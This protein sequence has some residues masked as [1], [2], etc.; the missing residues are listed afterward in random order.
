MENLSKKSVQGQHQ[1]KLT[2]LMLKWENASWTLVK[3]I[4][5]FK[6]RT[7]YRNLNENQL[8][9]QRVVK[10]TCNITGSQQKQLCL[11]GYLLRGQAYKTDFLHPLID[12]SGNVLEVA[13]L[14]FMCYEKSEFKNY[15]MS[16]QTMLSVFPILYQSIWWSMFLF[17]FVF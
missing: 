1:Q 13:V 8:K 16:H 15:I 11:L 12:F 17:I 4:T 2:V 5:S 7:C 9:L 14:N 3:N 6:I 10:V